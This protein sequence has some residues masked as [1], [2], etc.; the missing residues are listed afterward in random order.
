MRI[1]TNTIYDM[2]VAGMQ[3]LTSDV[4]KTQLQITSGRRILT[5][6]DDPIASARALEV[7]QSQTLNLQYDSNIDS[8][9]SSLTP[10]DSIL[11]SIGNLIIDVRTTALSAENPLLTNQARAGIAS[12]LRGRYQELLGLANSTDGNGQYMFSGYNG[13]TRPFSDSSLG[14][15]T[16]SGD[17]GQRLVQ[18]SPSRQMAVS[19][20]GEDVFLSSKNGNGTIVSA[21]GATNGGSGVIDPATVT[22]I[23]DPNLRQPVTITFHT[24]YDGQFDVA[25]T[26]T[27][28]PVNV[29]YTSGSAISYNGWSVNVTG[30]PTA[31]DTFTV[32]PSSHVDVFQ[33]LGDFIKQLEMEIPAEGTQTQLA[34]GIK[35]AIQNFDQS[36]QAVLSVRASVG[37]RLQELDSAKLTGADLQLQYTQ[38][39]SNLQDVDP[40]KAATDLVRQKGALEAAQLSFTKIQ[41]LSLFDFIS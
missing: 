23:A 7:S 33:T 6:S 25:G 10:V 1:S 16:Y 31:G 29:P 28:N 14:N 5:P 30:T 19:D 11:D 18:I 9:I 36:L 12:G 13:A 38:T 17:Q 24:P 35:T 2:G 4:I 32:Q 41:G 39:L 8:A 3:Q 20:S 37:T 40:I 21:A 15:V 26:G 34:N 27:G 22:N